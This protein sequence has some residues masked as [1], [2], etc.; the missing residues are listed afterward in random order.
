MMHSTCSRQLDIDGEQDDQNDIEAIANDNDLQT[1]LMH[2]AS[3]IVNFAHSP[4][5]KFPV[6]TMKLHC[7]NQLI[8][9]W[10]AIGIFWGHV[11]ESSYLCSSQQSIADFLAFMR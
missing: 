9:L 4:K 1:S 11:S 6:L 8:G 3:E 7:G 10:H 5:I 2:C